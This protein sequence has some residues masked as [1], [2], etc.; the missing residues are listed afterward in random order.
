[1]I[2]FEIILRKLGLGTFQLL[3][4]GAFCY[5]NMSFGINTL[6]TVFIAYESSYR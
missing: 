6:A 2:K 1:M 3:V 5:F 4:I